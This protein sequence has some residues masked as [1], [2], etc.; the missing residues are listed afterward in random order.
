MTL[1][2]W[3]VVIMI[4]CAAM[5]LVLSTGDKATPMELYANEKTG[6]WTMFYIPAPKVACIGATGDNFV[7]LPVGDPA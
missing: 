3:I 4:G 7:R 6:S 5:A 1:L 2:R